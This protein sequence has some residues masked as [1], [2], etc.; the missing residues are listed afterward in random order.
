M[1]KQYQV[2]KKDK[3]YLK[4][5]VANFISGLGT[6]I[7]NIAI[8][9]VT[10]EVTQSVFWVALIYGCSLIPNVLLGPFFGVIIERMNKKRALLIGDLCGATLMGTLGLLYISGHLNPIIMLIIIFL[11][12]TIES[13]VTPA[14]MSILPRILKAENYDVGIALSQTLSS[15]ASLIGLSMAG[16]I[17]AFYG[18]SAAIFMDATTFLLSFCIILFVKDTTPSEQTIHSKLSFKRFSAEFKEGLSYLFSNRMIKLVC[19]AGFFI[20]F[21]T[22]AINS[23]QVVYIEDSLGLGSSEYA[24]LMVA[25]A[26][27]SIVGG[28]MAPRLVG[29][30]SFKKQLV[31]L[32]LMIGSEYVI[33]ALLPQI[34]MPYVSFGIALILEC[35]FGMVVAM[36]TVSLSSVFLRA[37]E[38]RYLAR[39]ASTFN[40]IVTLSMPIG[41]A[42]LTVCGLCL[43][44]NQIFFLFG[45]LS[46]ITCLGIVALTRGIDQVDQTEPTQ[47]EPITEVN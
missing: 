29:K 19:F 44:V 33:F 39:A 17:I 22:V 28:I 46:L 9:W 45:C 26:G 35:I 42:V 12:A 41:S 4:M 18:A 15:V 8:A 34:K 27:A 6:H 25:F 37:I 38:E 14:G 23:L 31:T 16:F 43:T 24:T 10:Y 21:V 36:I 47:Q 3:A 13:F 32:A 7:D 30:V 2:L 20:N 1:F 5:L 40:A 11:N